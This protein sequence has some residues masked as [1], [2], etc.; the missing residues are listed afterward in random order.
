LPRFQRFE[1]WTQRNITGLLDT[2][3][4]ELPAGALLILEVGDEEPFVSRPMAGA[5]ATGDRIAE[6]LLDGQQR[7]TALWRSLTDDYPDRMYFV[8]VTEDEEDEDDEFTGPPRAISQGRWYREGKVYPRWV[9]EPARVWARGL[10]PAP[11]LRPD[12]DGEEDFKA[13]A[14]AA[15][16]GDTDTL[17][18]LISLGTDLRAQFARFNLPFLSLP[19]TTA[20]EIALDVFVKMNTAAQPLSTYDIVVAQVE[21]GTGFSLHEL[22]AELRKEAPALE[23][24]ADAAQV[25]LSAGALLQ[26]REPSQAVMLS[27]DFAEGLIDQWDRLAL[28]AQRAARFLNDEYVFDAARLPSDPSVPALVALWAH[29]PDGLDAEGQARAILR[30]FMWRAFLTERYEY[31]TNSRRLSD[32]R[33]IRS[34]LAGKDDGLPPIFNEAAH[35]LPRIEELVLAGWPKKRERLARALL[36][37]SLRGGGIDLADGSPATLDNLRLREYH[38]LFPVA[39]LEKQGI[40]SG[41]IFRA[42][43]CALVTWKTNRTIA[44]KSPVEY[45]RERI[46]AARLGEEEIRRR[47]ISHAIDYDAL[48]KG[49]YDAFLQSRSERILPDVVALGSVV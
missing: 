16:E 38:H 15:S 27:A 48:A 36:L 23:V 5:P 42:L 21:A 11:L 32:Y 12:A 9:E 39:F 31:A 18:E 8:K 26:D 19:A 35:P 44:A 46:D 13:W 41:K 49:D 47:L 40:E 4:R 6:H 30:S 22:E 43:N 3:L 20:R 37:I 7:L 14:R 29:A 10:I 45:L 34:R 28:G 1:A 24:F 17:I 2:V 33:L 25:I